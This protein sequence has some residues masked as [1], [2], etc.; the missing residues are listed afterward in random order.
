MFLFACEFRR[1]WRTPLGSR[2]LYGLRLAATRPR[3]DRAR[4]ADPNTKSRAPY[5]RIFSDDKNAYCR[6]RSP[7]SSLG[8]LSSSSCNSWRVSDAREIWRA[9]VAGTGGGARRRCT[10]IFRN[11]GRGIEIGGGELSCV[12]GVVR[13]RDRFT[14]FPD[15]NY[16]SLRFCGG[17][18]TEDRWM[19]RWRHS[20]QYVTCILRERSAAT[21]AGRKR[22]LQGGGG[23]PPR[24]WPRRNDDRGRT[25]WK[26][27]N[28]AVGDRKLLCAGK[29][30][31]QIVWNVFVFAGRGKKKKCIMTLRF[32]I[33]PTA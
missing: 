23:N 15:I 28:P 12:C 24:A 18:K 4:P 3:S 32:R 5:L 7:L 8:D 25:N 27:T 16:L 6:R 22:E 26:T 1:D 19:R 13:A 31:P 30:H 10:I 21:T 20:G 17:S 14:K 9:N 11:R 33:S 2:R 29:V